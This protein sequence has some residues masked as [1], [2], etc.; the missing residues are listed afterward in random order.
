MRVRRVCSPQRGSISPRA[1]SP[2]TEDGK[3]PRNRGTG[4]RNPSQRKEEWRMGSGEREE[5][6][7]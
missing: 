5:A 4:E 7:Q 2:A 1:R 6:L 3:S